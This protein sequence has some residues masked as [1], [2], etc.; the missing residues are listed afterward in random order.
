MIFK[1][2]T[3]LD[4]RSEFW[5]TGGLVADVLATRSERP[6]NGDIGM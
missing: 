3:G 1:V 4:G 2:G 5:K 6:E